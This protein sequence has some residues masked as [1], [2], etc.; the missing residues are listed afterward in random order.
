M[1][2]DNHLTLLIK[3]YTKN[4]NMDILKIF[5]EALQEIEKE[6]YLSKNCISED[7]KNGMLWT[8]HSYKL[9]LEIIKNSIE[10]DKKKDTVLKQIEIVF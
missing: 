6:I 1:Y 10:Q 9:R 7:Y 8:L 2:Y 5:N 3:Q 4:Q